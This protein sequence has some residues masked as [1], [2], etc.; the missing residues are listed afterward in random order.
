MAHYF[1][2]LDTES[3]ELVVKNRKLDA[4]IEAYQEMKV[5]NRMNLRAR[6]NKKRRE[7]DSLK[8]QLYEG[9]SE[10]NTALED[11]SDV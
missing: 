4:E 8:E 2:L 11:Y 5:S 1:N 9:H 7:A 3:D 10:I 6:V